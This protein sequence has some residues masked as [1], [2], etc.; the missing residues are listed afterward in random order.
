MKLMESL[1][2]SKCNGA[3]RIQST[4]AVC[5]K[6][7]FVF[8]KK[9]DIW[10][11][12]I[13]SRTKTEQSRK[14][15]EKVHSRPLMGPQDGSYDVLGAIARGNRTLDIACGDGWI[16]SIAPNT[17]SVDF[18]KNA[19]LKARQKGGKHLVLAD[20]HHLPFKNDS[21]DVCICAGSLEHFENPKLAIAE[22]SRVS[23][24]QILTVHRRPQF[25]GFGFVFSSLSKLLR[26]AHQPIDN[27]LTEQKL[28]FLLEKAG[29]HIVFKGVWT[30][31]AN[32]GKVI[33][34]L[35][36]IKIYPSV[37]FTISIKK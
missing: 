21:F 8:L 3:L 16:E 19:L 26:I 4:K 27:P 7:K 9:G 17:V 29:L 31:P 37:A 32:Y 6:C 14:E 35:P 11:F 22:M 10:N 36:E 20:S 5:S 24:I 33:T 25:F 28:H 13:E 18:S 34:W 12:L 23:K 15:Y 2:C 1:Q 30:L